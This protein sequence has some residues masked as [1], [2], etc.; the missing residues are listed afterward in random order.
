LVHFV[1]KKL[2]G[3]PMPEPPSTPQ[4]PEWFLRAVG[5][6]LEN[7]GLLI[8]G[9]AYAAN[10]GVW[11]AA[12]FLSESQGQ[13]E[14]VFGHKW[15]KEDTFS[16]PTALDRA[17]RWLLERYGPCD[18][19]LSTLPS[20]PLVLDAGCGAAYSAL[21]Y[22]G[23]NFSDIR[24]V[25]VDVS[26]AVQ[27]ALRRIKS[28][29]FDG[30]FLRD[31]LAG[32]PFAPA[33]FDLIFC[34]GVLHHT[35]SPRATLASLVELLRPGGLCLFYVYNKKG[36]IR[37]FTD[38]YIRDRLQAL[39]PEAAWEALRPLTD[40]GLKLG[41]LDVE[42]DLP[43]GL[44]L[45]NVPAGSISLQRFFYYHVLKA[46]YAPELTFDEMLHINFDWF[47]PRNAHRQTPEEVRSWCDSLGLVT[48]RFQVE[49]SGIT[50]AARKRRGI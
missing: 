9:R 16:S 14:K 18:A 39:S 33:G 41:R 7:G 1:K 17:R 43:D 13:T 10:D 15:Q 12:A 44:P 23:P 45:L 46:F 6:R 48:E 42:L 40:L 2:I 24:Y 28:R 36:P 30:V 34:E 49:P 3:P 11:R 25:G 35:D 21:E 4:A 26:E 19:W 47:A 29:G 20:S 22:F 37:E 8:A 38:D 5:G 27:V 50:V 31:D 32:L